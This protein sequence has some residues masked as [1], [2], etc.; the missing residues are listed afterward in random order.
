MKIYLRETTM[1]SRI[2][3]LNNASIYYYR[4]KDYKVEVSVDD[5]T[6]TEVARGTLPNEGD[7]WTEV[8]F[9]PVPAKYIRFTGIE[10]Y[11]LPGTVGLMEME[12]Y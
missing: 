3:M 11:H 5:A 1:V 6:W 8:S 12:V 2:R 10:G 7:T 9:S 4:T